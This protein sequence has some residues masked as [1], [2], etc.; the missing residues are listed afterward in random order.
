VELPITGFN[1]MAKPHVTQRLLELKNMDAEGL[2][3]QTLQKT[4]A[5]IRNQESQNKDIFKVCLSLAD[6]HM[7]G[8]TNSYTTDYQSKFAFQAFAKRKFC[9]PYLFTKET[10]SAQKIINRTT[11]YCYRT[12]YWLDHPQK[13]LSLEDH[14]RQEAAV[15]SRTVA[16]DLTDEESF[17]QC[18]SLYETQR[19]T[20]SY[21]FIFAFLYGD[22]AAEELGHTPLGLKGEAPGF[23]F[24]ASLNRLPD[25]LLTFR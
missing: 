18:L 8:W 15:L 3:Q 16:E 13:P 11:E 25:L 20:E 19:T 10:F 7:G 14:I 22:Q 21:P 23:K 1:P 2:M 5:E 6:D 12:L 4:N 9:I 24:A 17:R